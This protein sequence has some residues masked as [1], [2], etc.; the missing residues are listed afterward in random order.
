MELTQIGFLGFGNMAKA[1]ARGMLQS[2]ISADQIMISAKTDQTKEEGATNFGIHTGTNK[3]VVAKSRVIIVAVKP[4]VT[5]EVL[6]EIVTEWTDDK[7]LIT[8]AAG[9][10]MDWVQ[11]QFSSHAK[12]VRTM[13]NTP[14]LVGEGMTAW[15]VNQ[16]VNE[17]E[18]QAI[19]R[20]L[21]TF[22]K[23][24]LLDE[25]LQDEI[26]AISGSSPAYVYTL[27]ETMALNG[28]R[29][30]ISHDQ[31][32][33]LAAQTVVGAGKMVLETGKHPALLRDE[34]CTAGGS[35]IEAVLTLEDEGFRRA[36]SRAMQ[37]CAEKTKQLGAK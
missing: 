30:G 12:V 16:F 18:V 22:G 37:A 19:G 14:S 2:G 21:R 17:E 8:I 24:V 3:E 20:L 4:H 13:P 31:A 15:S 10:S 33:T 6:E 25:S 35:T 32:I 5:K 7:I 1:I 27:I 26:P 34:V 29:S 23:E 28:V 9:I 11:H 36:I